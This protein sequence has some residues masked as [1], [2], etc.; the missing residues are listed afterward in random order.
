[1]RTNPNATHYILYYTKCNANSKI[2]FKASDIILKEHS[3]ASYLSEMEARSRA[4]GYHYLGNKQ[5]PK[6]YSNN[7]PTDINIPVAVLVSILHNVFSSAAE[8][9]IGALFMNTKDCLYTCKCLWE[10][11]GIHNH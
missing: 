4:G 1:M 2:F 7:I 5:G 8:A 10:K 3:D 11:R 6:F 9:E